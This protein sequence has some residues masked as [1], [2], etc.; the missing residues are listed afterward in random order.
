MKK[1]ALVRKLCGVVVCLVFVMALFCG[2]AAALFI[3]ALPSYE[4]V[5]DDLNSLGLFKGSDLGYELERAPKR[6]EAGTMLLRLLGLEE[7]AL[8]GDYEHPFTDVPV[9]A[10][11]IVGYLYENNLTNGISET[12]FGSD[13]ECDARMYVTF[14]L[15]ALGYSDKDGD[16]TYAEAVEFGMSVGVIDDFILGTKYRIPQSEDTF[17][18]DTRFL[19]GHMTAVSLLALYAATADGE[20]DTM[21]EKLVAEGVVDAGAA[22]PI[23]E[24]NQYYNELKALFPEERTNISYDVKTNTDTWD[25]GRVDFYLNVAYRM[26]GEEMLLSMDIAAPMLEGHEGSMRYKDGYMYISDLNKKERQQMSQEDALFLFE[27]N[28]V[29]VGLDFAF[30]PVYTIASVTKETEVEY[31]VYTETRD[32]SLGAFQ[33]RGDGFYSTG[34]L[35]TVT[36]YYFNKGGQLVKIIYETKNDEHTEVAN[37]KFGEDVK[38]VFPEDLD[39]YVDVSEF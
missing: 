10:D 31:T 2:S 22:K 35:R 33:K 28:L 6:V 34:M 17:I 30:T 14:V 25:S 39:S 32:S 1:S 26:D 20:Y 5:A 18:F 23:L 7:V 38:I 9:W 8:A 24:H 4:S 37:F 21:L 36:K 12:L 15:R 13:N 29:S 27:E 16:F 19:R 11:K 3:V